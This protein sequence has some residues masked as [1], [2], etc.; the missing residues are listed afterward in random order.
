MLYHKTYCNPNTSEW[1]IFIHGAGGSSAVWFKQIKFFKRYFNLLLIDLRGHGSSKVHDSLMERN[2]YTFESVSEDIIEVMDYL[3]IG[4]AHF[5]GVSLGTIII[6]QLADMAEYRV[7]SM[8]MT[9]AVTGLN[10]Q[11]RFWVGLG[12]LFRHVLPHMWLYQL[13][14]RVIM[15]ASSQKE[16]RSVFIREAQKLARKEFLRWFTLT[17]ELTGLLKKFEIKTPDIPVL[18][19]MGDQDYLFI[20]NVRK[21]AS[22]AGNHFLEIVEQCGHVVNIE[23]ASHFNHKALEFLKSEYVI[24]K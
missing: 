18:Y 10:I 2:A 13:F 7:K 6:R 20:D 14:A 5:I 16:S 15:P 19:I 9:G 12:R 11:S 1:V 8:I 23:K 3:K 22:S 24:S 21:I 4:K 17:G